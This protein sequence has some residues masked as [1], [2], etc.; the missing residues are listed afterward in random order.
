MNVTGELG[1]ELTAIQEKYDT[2]HAR[3]RPTPD[4][5]TPEQQLFFEACELL[6]FSWLLEINEDNRVGYNVYN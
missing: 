2:F 3:R 1:P 6:Y 4:G 5:L